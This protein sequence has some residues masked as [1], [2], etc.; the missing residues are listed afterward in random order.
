MIKQGTYISPSK[1]GDLVPCSDAAGE[2]EEIGS[3]VKM[4]KK[5]SFYIGLRV[6]FRGIGFVRYS[7]RDIFMAI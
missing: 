6:D 5:V 7:I 1:K 3:E 4:F 2:V